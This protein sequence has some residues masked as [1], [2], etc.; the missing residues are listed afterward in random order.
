M[1][2]MKASRMRR[3]GELSMRR[4][5]VWPTLW[6]SSRVGLPAANPQF[7]L[8]NSNQEHWVSSKG[9]EVSTLLL[10][11]TVRET[12][13]WEFFTSHR[14]ECEHNDI[15]DLLILRVS[16]HQYSIIAGK[17]SETRP[18]SRSFSGGKP[19]RIRSTE[20]HQHSEIFKRNNVFYFKFM[21]T[22]LTDGQNITKIRR[23]SKLKMEKALL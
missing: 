15:G 8:I 11:V 18:R 7:Y 22:E 14:G 10:S 4:M 16:S 20:W 2:R 13:C 3:P 6:T 9:E 12:D 21:V 17:V 5:R 1:R 19:S 23:Y